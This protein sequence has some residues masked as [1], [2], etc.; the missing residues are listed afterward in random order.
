MYNAGMGVRLNDGSNIELYVF[1]SWGLSFSVLVHRDL[2][3]DFDFA[4]DFQWYS[5]AFLGSPG[6]VSTCSLY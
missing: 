5:L 1:V 4:S 2:T 6:V 3:D